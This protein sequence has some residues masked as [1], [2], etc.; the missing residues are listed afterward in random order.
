MRRQ[1]PYLF[2]SSPVCTAFWTWQALKYAKSS[3]KA[4]LDRAYARA[5][6]CMEFVA[7]LYAEQAAAGRYFLHEHPSGASSWGFTAVKACRSFLE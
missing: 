3:D 7:G 2:I 5:T 6:V 4:A 1:K